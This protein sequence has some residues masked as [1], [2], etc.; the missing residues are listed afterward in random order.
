MRHL[1]LSFR[2]LLEKHGMGGH[3]IAPKSLVSFYKL[4]DIGD[5]VCR[6]LA[7]A[8]VYHGHD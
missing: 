3:R 8:D 1:T 5:I 2:R 7:A 6:C 4:L